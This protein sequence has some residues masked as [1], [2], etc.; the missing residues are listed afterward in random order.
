MSPLFI[1]LTIGAVYTVFA[2]ALGSA[3]GKIL[4]DRRERDSWPV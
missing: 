2:F 4:K 3:I 1:G